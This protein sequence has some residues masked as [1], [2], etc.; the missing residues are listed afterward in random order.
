MKAGTK[1]YASEQDYT[2]LSALDP[3]DPQTIYVSTFFDPRN[4]TTMSTK[5]EIWRGTTCDNGATF[6]WTPVT[7]R[8][9]MDNIRPIVPKWDGSHTAL[10]WMR[11]TYTSAQSYSMKIVGTLTTKPDTPPRVRQI[12]ATTRAI[13]STA[14][15][16]ISAE[17]LHNS[18]AWPWKSPTLR[19]RAR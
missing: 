1:L 12:S 11:G 15:H 17:A 4:D 5:R 6:T 14:G 3:D 13:E 8:S 7:A 19:G 16:R 9:T 10:L 2:G 18:G